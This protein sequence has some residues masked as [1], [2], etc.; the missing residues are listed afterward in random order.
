M[1]KFIIVAVII[2]L[3]NFILVSCGTDD[4]TPPKKSTPIVTKD[5]GEPEADYLIDKA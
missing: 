5:P 1:K 2:I 4:S 3:F